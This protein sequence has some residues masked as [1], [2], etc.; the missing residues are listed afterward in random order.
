MFT[1]TADLMLPS[2]VTGSFPRPRWFDVSMW[3]KPLDT[4][5]LDVRFREK[6]Q[7]ALAV[8]VSDQERAGLD[9]LT[10]AISTATKTS[11]AAPGTTIPSSAGPAWTATSSR[12]RRP[13]REWLKYP[14][15]TLLHEIYTGWRWPRVI[16]KIEHRPLD[17]PKI[18]RM[19]QAKTPRPVKFGTCCSQVM[20]LFLDIHTPKLQGQAGSD[21]GHGRG[22]EQGAAGP[23]R[24][25][26]QVHPGG[27]ALLP[28]HGQHLRQGP[29][30]DP[31]HDRRLQ[32]RGRRAGRRGAVDPHLLG[33]PQHAAGPRRHQLRRLDG[34]LPGTRP[35][36][37]LDGGDEGPQLPRHRAVRA[38]QAR[39]EE[40]GGH[41]R[42]QPPH[43]CK[44]TG[45]K[46]WPPRSAGR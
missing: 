17:Y 23:A 26:L 7:D 28:L 46:T 10:T 42:R 35:G 3:G 6:F 14:P 5:M 22:H 11:P 38:L 45:R 40:E 1:V 4:C 33:Q 32:P 29:R 13:A 39:P 34:D 31:L 19:T 2:T 9:I 43:R 41:R 44:P 27:R 12:P 25:G 15:G 30:A 36:R 21:L 20:S 16:D 18:W 37:R 24:R 8:V